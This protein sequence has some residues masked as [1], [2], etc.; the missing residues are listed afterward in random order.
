MRQHTI[1]W[2]RVWKK[3]CRSGS[4]EHFSYK[5][6]IQL[7]VPSPPYPMYSDHLTTCSIGSRTISILCK[8]APLIRGDNMSSHHVTSPCRHAPATQISSCFAGYHSRSRS[9]SDSTKNYCINISIIIVLMC[10]ICIIIMCLL[11]LLCTNDSCYK[12]VFLIL[13]IA[14]PRSGLSDKLGR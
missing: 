3:P 13:M 4:F 2:D 14:L 12:F 11:L 6:G 8:V 10:V 7:G 1:F 9:K 5:L